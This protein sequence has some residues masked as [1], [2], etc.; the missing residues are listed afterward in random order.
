[1]KKIIFA[2][3]IFTFSL[4]ATGCGPAVEYVGRT[5]PQTTNVDV[6]FNAND[7]QK[8]YEVIG[9][10]DGQA[11]ELTNFQKIQDKIVEEAKKRGADGVIFTTVGK[12]VVGTTQNQV[13]EATGGSSKKTT[14]DE[15]N[16]KTVSNGWNASISTTTTTNNQRV[17]V[18]RADFIKYK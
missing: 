3:S 16:N 4:M 12:E 10:V 17:K 8:Q 6:Y 2:I 9:K 13:T 11:W 7:V 5:L 1:M 18:M 15:D 14:G